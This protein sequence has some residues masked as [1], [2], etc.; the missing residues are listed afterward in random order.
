LHAR[1]WSHFYR[2]HERDYS[3]VPA[4]ILGVFTLGLYL[5]QLVCLVRWTKNS[6]DQGSLVAKAMV[7]VL[8]ALFTPLAWFILMLTLTMMFSP[9]DP[10][11]GRSL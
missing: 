7:S 2:A 11:S 8:V 4:I 3:P 6:A 5:Y 9:V 1:L 10:K